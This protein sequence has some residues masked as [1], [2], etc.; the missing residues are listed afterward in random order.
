MKAHVQIE[1]AAPPAG[2]WALLVD[3][4]S[5]PTWQKNINRVTATGP[6]ARGSRFTWQTGGT[7]IHSQVQLFEPGQRLAWTGTAMTAKAVHVWQ[8]KPLPGN[9]TLVI[10]D[11]SMDGPW[12]AKMY[13]SEK[14]AASDDDWLRALKQ[15][16]ETMR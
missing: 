11:E 8:L 12:M 7:T 9:R 4:S 1:I 2:V 10:V 15:A 6:L 16:A 3:A 13:P 5:W 14:L